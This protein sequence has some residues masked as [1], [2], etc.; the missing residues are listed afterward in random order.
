[1][2][3]IL[4]TKRW[5]IRQL[6]DFKSIA[7]ITHTKPDADALCSALAL[8]RVL[9]S[10]AKKDVIIDIFVDCDEIDGIYMPIIG[11]EKI[12]VRSLRKNYKYKLAIALDCANKGRMGKNIEIFNKAYYTLNIDHHDTND[13]FAHQNYIKKAS[14][15]CEIIFDLCNKNNLDMDNLTNKLLYSGIIT[16][17]ANLTQGNITTDTHRVIMCIIKQLGNVDNLLDYFFKNKK[18]SKILLLEKALHSLSF[19]V[20]DKVAFM[21]LMK[22][23]FIS[24][25]STFDDTNGI[26]NYAIDIKGVEIAVIAIKQEDNSYYFSLRSKQGID[27]AHIASYFGGGGHETMA[28]FQYKGS[29]TEIKTEL[30]KLAKET[31]KEEHIELEI[32][33]FLDN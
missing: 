33:P 9:K 4:L 6:V 32:N 5:T 28:A 2:Y 16:D 20:N 3:R 23:D 8:K 21:R 24:T 26:I 30:L 25:D 31:L 7:I 11:D 18:K 1:M 29:L 15:T 13:K 22:T 10:I 19:Y 17:T 14:S 12:N 27:V